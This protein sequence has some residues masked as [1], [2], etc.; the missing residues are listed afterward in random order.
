MRLSVFVRLAVLLAIMAGFTA[1]SALAVDFVTYTDQAAFLAAVSGPA[2]D[3]FNDL[4]F[5]VVSSPL[6]RTIGTYQYTA[7]AAGDFFPAGTVGDVWLSTNGNLDP[8]NFTVTAGG[9]TAMGGFFFVS[10]VAGALLTGT[11]N[12]SINGG[13]FQQSISTGSATN[14]FGWVSTNGTPISTFQVAASNNQPGSF[15][16]ATVNDLVLAQAVPEPS[17]Y[18]LGTLAALTLGFVSRRRKKS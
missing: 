13:Q 9:P 17:T 4:P 15:F 8:I 10:D 11:I 16:F 3:P 14:F 7:T 2:T 5:D 1:S 12:V 6:N 18:A